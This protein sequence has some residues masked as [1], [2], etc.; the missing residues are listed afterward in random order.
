MKIRIMVTAVLL[1]SS[2]LPVL[3]QSPEWM[4]EDCAGWAQNFFQD[5]EAKTEMKYEGQR[6]DGTH[7][8]NG[9]I[10]LETRSEEIQC[11]YAAAG[12]MVVD[13]FAEGKSWPG[14]VKGDP[15]PHKG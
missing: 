1:T 8:M 6:T 7:A 13:F 4:A 10:Y 2:G 14:F 11:S 3:A 5:Y 9:T 15:S 12:A